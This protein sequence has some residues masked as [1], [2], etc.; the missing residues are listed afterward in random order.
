MRLKVTVCERCGCEKVRPDP[1]CHACAHSREKP[2]RAVVFDP[3][4]PTEIPLTRGERLSA[5]KQIDTLMHEKWL[6]QLRVYILEQALEKR[7]IVLDLDTLPNP[8]ES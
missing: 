4:T 7:G 8:V 1:L 6:L 2:M 3:P 5:V